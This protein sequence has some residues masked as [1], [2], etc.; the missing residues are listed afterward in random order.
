MSSWLHLVADNCSVPGSPQVQLPFEQLVQYDG[1]GNRNCQ[2]DVVVRACGGLTIHM[3]SK[4]M[5]SDDA[6]LP[7]IYLHETLIVKNRIDSF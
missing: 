3:S 6:A 5:D 1:T 4:E 7:E 2:L